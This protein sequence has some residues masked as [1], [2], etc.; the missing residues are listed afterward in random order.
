LAIGV[1]RVP[2]KRGEG[3]GL[4]GVVTTDL[5]AEVLQVCPEYVYILL[6]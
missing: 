4:R 1:Y 5:H 2:E 3:A 6:A